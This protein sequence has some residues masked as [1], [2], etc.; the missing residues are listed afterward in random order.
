MS[1]ASPGRYQSRLFNFLNRQSQ[2]LTEQ[3]DRAVRHLKVATV[4]GV[5][6]LVY[7]VYLMVQGGLSAGRQLSQSAQAG[8]PQFKALTNTHTQETPPEADTPIQRVLEEIATLPLPKVQGKAVAGLMAGKAESNLTVASPQSLIPHPETPSQLP[9]LISSASGE[10][11]VASQSDLSST[12][13]EISE[14][15]CLIQG[16]ATLLETH[17]LVLITVE[18]QILDI[19][20]P[21]Q[22]QRLSSKISWEVADLRRQWRLAQASERHFTQRHLSSLDRPQVF[23]PV[24][25]FWNLMAWVQTSPIAVAANLFQE[26]TLVRQPTPIPSSRQSLRPTGRLRSQLPGLNGGE[27]TPQLAPQSELN[28]ASAPWAIAFLDRTVAELESHQLIPGTEVAIAL[29]DQTVRSLKEGTQKFLQKIQTPFTTPASQAASPE[30]SH[31]N[32]FRIQALIYAAVDYFFGRHS[33]HLPGTVAGERSAIEA[34]PQGDVHHLSGH[35]STSLVSATQRPNF[36]IGVRGKRFLSLVGRTGEGRSN[37]EFSDST[38]PD[39][40]LTTS[41]LFGNPEVEGRTQ[42]LSSQPP[43]IKGSKSKAQLPE[44]FNSKTPIVVGNSGWGAI[45]RYL[46]FN[47]RPGTLTPSST[48]ELSVEPQA[49][50]VQPTRDKTLSRPKTPA[51]TKLKTASSIANSSRSTSALPTATPSS[52]ITTPSSPAQDAHLEAT[53]DWIETPAT[54]TGYVKHPLEQLLEWLDTAM[55]WLEDLVV[56]AWQWLKHRG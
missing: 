12:A 43:L 31:P 45:A 21:Q 29:S 35:Q 36:K 49:L 30:V 39:P 55:L 20:T 5:Q 50:V 18:N 53:P 40:W 9:N 48:G 52:A 10:A 6:I 25:L 23:L 7:P 16:V 41:D 2:R 8:W 11:T 27:I 24:R 26:S 28:S 56:K 47:Q 44:A 1:S 15:Y 42:N 51:S 13:Q 22:Q 4:W 14:E 33:S 32:T 3:C 17:A 46:S 34:N 37:L 54:P 19:L 38:E